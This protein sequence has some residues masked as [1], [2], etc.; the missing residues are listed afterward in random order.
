MIRI[1]CLDDLDHEPS[2]CILF[3]LKV[4]GSI[5][6]CSLKQVFKFLK[7]SEKTFLI[8]TYFFILKRSGIENFFPLDVEIFPFQVF[9]KIIFNYICKG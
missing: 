8:T 4:E 5:P 3:S 1:N 2:F 6:L 7:P 9:G